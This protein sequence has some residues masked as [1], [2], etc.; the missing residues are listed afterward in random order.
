MTPLTYSDLL[1]R[2]RGKASA[3]RCP[4]C[5]DPPTHTRG[6]TLAAWQALHEADIHERYADV[7]A[8]YK[9]IAD[10]LPSLHAGNTDRPLTAFVARYRADRPRETTLF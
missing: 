4:L 10:R 8:A 9:A 6:F 3:Y 5:V 1:D 7:D 2:A